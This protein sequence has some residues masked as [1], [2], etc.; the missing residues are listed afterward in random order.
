ME[1]PGVPLAPTA[2]ADNAERMNGTDTVDTTPAEEDV[3]DAQGAEVTLPKAMQIESVSTRPITRTRSR[4]FPRRSRGTSSDRR[5]SSIKPA[6]GVGT[7][8]A[9]AAL[10]TLHAR[11]ARGSTSASKGSIHSW[12]L[13]SKPKNSWQLPPPKRSIDAMRDFSPLSSV[14]SP[15]SS[16]VAG[17]TSTGLPSHSRTSTSKADRGVHVLALL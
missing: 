3:Q 1:K 15:I 16:S 14:A 17:A 10:T 12:P 11:G 2:R 13:P 9:S 5:S 7:M 4:D 8:P 6:S